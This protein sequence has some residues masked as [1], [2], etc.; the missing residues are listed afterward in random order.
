MKNINKL[1]VFFMITFI[2]GVILNI[3]ILN[4]FN[5]SEKLKTKTSLEI[6]KICLSTSD[7]DIIQECISKKNSFSLQEY[8][9]FFNKNKEI[10]FKY[11]ILNQTWDIEFFIA[12]KNC[13]ENK[14]CKVKDSFALLN[15][16]KCATKNTI[17]A[18]YI[19][20][21]EE[22]NL[23]Q[24]IKG[25]NEALNLYKQKKEKIREQYNKKYDKNFF[26]IFY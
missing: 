9:E 17:C 16:I 20:E 18:I 2:I 15:L 7:E 6:N 23:M 12:Y 14:D 19:Y 10:H 26:A 22:I 5:K 11:P 21:K 24:E 3:S 8:Y 1:I 4:D 25:N 13:F